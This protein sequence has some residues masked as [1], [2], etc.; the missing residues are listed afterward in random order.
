MLRS[1]RFLLASLGLVALAAPGCTEDDVLPGDGDSCNLLAGDLV[2]TEI[3][4]NVPGSDAG[5]EWFEIYNASSNPIELEGRTLIYSK[6]DGTRRKSHTIARSLEIPPG[7]YLT[8]GSVLDEVAQSSDHLDYGYGQD[9]G[10]FGNTGGYLAIECDDGE[11]VDETYYEEVSDAASRA[12]D[13]SRVPDAVAND[14]V[15]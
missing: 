6:I 8:V 11:L 5:Q 13:G 14:F 9:L 2:I 3:V 4:A 1:N 15:A 7:G 10:E 12:F